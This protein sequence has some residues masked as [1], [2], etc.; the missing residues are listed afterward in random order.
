[1]T[2]IHAHF[3][4]RAVSILL[5]A[6]LLSA[7]GSDGPDAPHVTQD[8][9]VT[10]DPNG[11]TPL[12]A[13]LE[14]STQ[15]PVKVLLEISD[16]TSVRQL[17][18]NKLETEHYIP[19]L[20][21]FPDSA[22]TV[23]VSME[24]K[25]GNIWELPASVGQQI[26]QTNSLPD[27]FPKI[28]VHVSKPELME[29][30]YT[31]LDRSSR[32]RGAD[33]LL[34]IYSIILDSAGRVVWYTLSSHSASNMA[35]LPN[36]NLIYRDEGEVNEMTMLGEKLSLIVLADPGLGLHHDLSVTTDGT[37]LSVS[38]E[39]F[40]YDNYPTNYTDP[41]PRQT[42]EIID[43]PIVEFS[44]D[45]EL[46]NIW[47]LKDMLDPSRIGYLA[48]EG[49]EPLDWVHV[50][51]VTYDSRDDSIIVSV[52]HQDAVIKFS[53]ET[54]ELIWILGPHNNWSES[55]QKYLL[56]PVGSDFAWQY[57]QH[58]PMITGD[59]TLLLFDNGNYKTSPFDGLESV[60]STD[61]F[62][63][64]VEFSIDEEK[65]EVEQVWEYGTLSSPRIYADFIGDAD[66]MPETGNALVHFGGTIFIDGAATST[67]GYGDGVTRI[68]EV[69]RDASKIKVFD[70]TLSDGAAETPLTTYRSE[71][72]KSLYPPE[73]TEMPV[74]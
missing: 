37:Y 36:G 22:Y 1:M 8:P 46:L 34:G 59:G 50:N 30:G 24:D 14:M 40:I 67:I 7:C 65:M 42:A 63:R 54:G 5:G 20:G 44:A 15:T 19:I 6:M 28:E 62:S 26:I 18:H 4:G 27:D 58:A 49:V 56:N 47:W 12:S 25:D 9:V 39:T 60:A 31:L 43:E 74:K 52:R 72:I 48:L 51:A 2:I 13:V 21:L 45:G 11:V 71:R 61:N 23:K 53:R 33:P 68:V 35:Q 41:I 57:H 64:A 17:K 3:A 70:V 55:F 16:G 69:T 38:R 10:L 73:Y 32:G 29:P 66:W